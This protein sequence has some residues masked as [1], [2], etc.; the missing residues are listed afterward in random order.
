MKN[1]SSILNS[2][3]IS[4]YSPI[5]LFF[6]ELIFCRSSRRENLSSPAG[7]SKKNGPKFAI[8]LIS[9]DSQ[10][11][12]RQNKITNPIANNNL[13]VIAFLLLYSIVK[14]RAKS[15]ANFVANTEKLIRNKIRDLLRAGE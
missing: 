9:A 8:G 7:R 10:I 13:L 3:F 4:R 5:I 1:L 11:G 2:S 14:K 12:V 15:I 6:P